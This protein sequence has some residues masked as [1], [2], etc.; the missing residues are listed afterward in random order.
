MMPGV[1]LN[2]SMV[3][4]LEPQ[5]NPSQLYEYSSPKLYYSQT[6]SRQHDYPENGSID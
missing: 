2:P 6:P 3:K 4:T 5:L 1:T